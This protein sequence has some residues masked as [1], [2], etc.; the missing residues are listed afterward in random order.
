MG[1]I[2]N[3]VLIPTVSFFSIF[4]P[5]S[6]MKCLFLVC[7]FA[8]AVF[9]APGSEPPDRRCVKPCLGNLRPNPVCGTDHFEYYNP[10]RLDVFICTARYRGRKLA[11]KHLGKCKVWEIHN[12]KQLP[13]LFHG[14][15]Q[16]LLQLLQQQQQQ[17]LQLRQQQQ[18]QQ[19][20]QLQ[21]QQQQQNNNNNYF[22]Q[23]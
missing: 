14:Q 4:F 20:L 3:F 12:P 9:A 1:F 11:L 2:S 21:Q 10:C 5:L 23:G 18:Q 6:K 22:R 8:I 7:C 17:L 15:Q 16:Q 13:L 19:L